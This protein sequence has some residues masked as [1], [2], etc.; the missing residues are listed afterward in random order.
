MNPV[1]CQY[2]ATNAYIRRPAV[3]IGDANSPVMGGRYKGLAWTCRDET[4]NST[5]TYEL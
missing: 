1:H 5:F 2:I 4:E 3:F